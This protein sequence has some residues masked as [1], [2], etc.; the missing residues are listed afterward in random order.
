ME[1]KKKVLTVDDNPVNNEIVIEILGDDYEVKTASTGKKA[2]EVANKFQPDLILLDIMM[3]GID[4]YETCK[5]LRSDKKF[6]HTVII[7]VSAKGLLE[8]KIEGYHAGA[9]DYITKPYTKENL[10]KSVEF[11]LSLNTNN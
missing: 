2:L 4:G 8:N 5:Q 9:Y 7:I 11:L 1:T 3:P 6:E 10:K